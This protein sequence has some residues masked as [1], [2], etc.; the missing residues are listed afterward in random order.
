MKAF[1][2]RLIRQFS[3]SHPRPGQGFV[4]DAGSILTCD[5]LTLALP[6]F[7]A[8]NL[9]QG[10]YFFNQI[11]LFASKDIKPRYFLKRKVVIR[12]FFLVYFVKPVSQLSIMTNIT[13]KIIDITSEEFQI[14]NEI[15]IFEGVSPELSSHLAQIPFVDVAVVNLEFKGTISLGNPFS[16]SCF[17]CYQVACNL[18][19]YF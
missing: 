13:T 6:S 10:T 9:C 4:L 14:S 7:A 11:D 2:H 19:R 18:L 17:R 15:L 1:L 3:L 12:Y 8:A 5:K 16:Q